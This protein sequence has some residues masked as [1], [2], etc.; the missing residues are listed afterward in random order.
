MEL[1]EAKKI[2]RDSFLFKDANE[3]IQ[4]KEAISTVLQALEVNERELESARK[5]I[6]EEED[7]IT[8]RNNKICELEYKNI[9][10]QKEN[11]LAR[12]SLIENSNIADER[13]DL[14]VEVQR[15]KDKPYGFGLIVGTKRERE[16]W[17]DKI[18]EKI[19]EIKAVTETCYGR[20]KY[21]EGKIAGLEELLKGE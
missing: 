9:E 5:F 7:A 13:N 4:L 15:L 14:L 18:K 8:E 1:K 6:D 16:Y 10:L 12:K 20:I 17:Q 2:I 11:E 21:Q 19:E 3:H